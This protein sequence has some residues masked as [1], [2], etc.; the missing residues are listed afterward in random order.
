MYFNIIVPLG[1]VEISGIVAK[2]LLSSSGVL[3]YSGPSSEASSPTVPIEKAMT[4]PL[5]KTISFRDPAEVERTASFKERESE[6]ELSVTGPGAQFYQVG[7]VNTMF[8]NLS[9][10]LL[11]AGASFRLS[12]I[13]GSSLIQ[14]L[15]LRVCW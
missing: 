5:D 9:T 13:H 2:Q 4:A 11:T 12:L 15:L 3:I 1:E 8:I 6:S 7:E 10:P 14:M